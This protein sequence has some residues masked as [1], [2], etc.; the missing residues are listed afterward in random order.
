MRKKTKEKLLFWFA[1]ALSVMGFIALI[2]LA[3]RAMEVI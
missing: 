3:L 1:I 2:I